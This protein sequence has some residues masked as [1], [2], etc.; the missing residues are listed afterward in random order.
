MS[1]SSLSTRMPP[2]H[3]HDDEAEVF[4]LLALMNF[5]LSREATRHDADGDLILLADQ[6]RSR[7]DAGHLAAAHAALN[8]ALALGAPDP[9]TL[10]AS[11]A[12][13][14]ADAATWEDTDWPRIVELYNQ[15]IALTRSPV[16]ELVR[17]RDPVGDVGVADL[18]L[19]PPVALP[20]G[21]FGHQEGTG[22][23]GCGQPTQEP[24]RQR[25]LGVG[26]ECGMAAKE[27]E[28]ELVVG[29]RVDVAEVGRRIGRGIVQRQRFPFPGIARRLAA[30]TIDR[31]VARRGGDPAAGVGRHAVDRPPVGGDRER[32]GD[33]VLGL[34]DVAQDPH[35]R[36]RAPADFSSVDGGE[37]VRVEEFLAQVDVGW[38]R[39]AWTTRPVSC[40]GNTTVGCSFP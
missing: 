3:D 10:Q 18:S 35:E 23:L 28:T 27:D 16:V 2:C 40:R 11:I 39:P 13:C 36:G 19:G 17:H 4:G 21:G 33:R 1:A 22:D 5:H 8:R 9:Y 15:L 32:I 26:T 31:P 6:E 25:D 38:P 14:H 7:W 37:L 29:H 12:A 24:Q 30:E 34:I 20:D